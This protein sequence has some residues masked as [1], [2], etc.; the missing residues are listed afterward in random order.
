[1][2]TPTISAIANPDAGNVLI[3][4]SWAGTAGTDYARVQRID[5]DGSL[6]TVRANTSVDA[7]GEYMELSAGQAILY[8]TEA[9][10]D[11]EISYVTDALGNDVD[12]ATAGPVTL[13][14]NGNVWL[15]DPIFPAHNVHIG[16][17]PPAALPECIPGDGIF[18]TGMADRNLG[19]QSTNWTINNRAT[20]LTLEQVRAAPTSALPLV[21]RTFDDYDILKLLTA[22]GTTLLLNVP[23]KYG[24]ENGYIAV[25]DVTVGRLSR[26]YTRQWQAANLPYAFVSR[27]AGLSYGVLGTRWI[28]ICDVYPTFDDA[29]AAD[30]TWQGIL[31][32]QASTTGAVPEFRTFDDVNSEFANWNA[33]NTGG[34]TWDDLLE[35]S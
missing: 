4:I 13:D 6:F 32:G 11:V 8:D 16:L 29:E 28:D 24:Y 21:L 34:R 33:V 15:T 18:F 26:D 7:S 14:S 25:G 9:P 20:P 17:T 5:P 30:L 35:G 23:A 3:M 12:S 2:S 31:L 19:V 22:A 27:P 1:M 10:F